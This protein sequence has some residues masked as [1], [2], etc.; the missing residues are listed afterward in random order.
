M[1]KNS[2]VPE[3]AP[4]DPMVPSSE[5]KPGSYLKLDSFLPSVIRNLAEG[6]TG[7]MSQNYT[8]D[9]QLTVTEW[10]IL[11]QLASAQSL[12]ATQIVE[13]TAM[14]KSKVSRALTSLEQR[15]FLVRTASEEDHRIKTLSLTPTGQKLYNNIVPRVLDWEKQLL[16]GFEIGEYRDLL[17]LLSKLQHRLNEMS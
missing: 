1:G 8:G 9:L 14:E 13:Y 16:D 10:R 2:P 17:Y 12:T 5:E 6:I 7:N 15:D 11:L 3:Q 4:I